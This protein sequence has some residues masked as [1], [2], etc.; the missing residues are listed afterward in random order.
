MPT[1]NFSKTDIAGNLGYVWSNLA[2]SD[3][4]DGALHGGTGDRTVQASGTFGAG[5]AVLIEGSLDG[6]NWFPLHDPQG[7]ALSFT[8]AGLRAILEHVLMVRPRVTGGDGT[9]SITT[10]VNVRR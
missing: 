3:T 6:N 8:A 5:G 1:I 9:T 10:I 7:V 4:G 2:V